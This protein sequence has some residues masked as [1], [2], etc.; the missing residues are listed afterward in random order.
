ME[1]MYLKYLSLEAPK[2][3]ALNEVLETPIKLLH[4]V[5]PDSRV[6]VPL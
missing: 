4:E 1:K 5:S 2:V 6:L 3:S